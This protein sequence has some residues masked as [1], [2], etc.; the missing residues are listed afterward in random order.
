MFHFFREVWPSLGGKRFLDTPQW[1]TK[2]FKGPLNAVN[3][4]VDYRG[5]VTDYRTTSYSDIKSASKQKDLLKAS[6][7][8]RKSSASLDGGK[9]KASAK[10]RRVPLGSTLQKS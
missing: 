8:L 1:M 4:E 9:R 6:A 5:H 3:G 7:T 2:T 10:K